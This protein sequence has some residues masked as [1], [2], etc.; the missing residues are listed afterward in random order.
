MTGVRKFDPRAAR[1]I[2]DR[3]TPAGGS[4]HLL[5]RVIAPA[6][7]A[8]I[9]VLARWSARSGKLRATVAGSVC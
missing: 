6:G 1:R 7:A 5:V 4:V 2:G 9:E 8:V 3:S